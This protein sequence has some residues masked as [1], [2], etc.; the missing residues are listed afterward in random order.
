M[1]DDIERRLHDAFDAQAR[2]SVGDHVAPP[3]PRFATDFGQGR[4]H[5]RVRIL[6][7]LAAAAA[8][9]VVG[10]S[11]LALQNSSDGKPGPVVGGH[12]TNPTRP[13]QAPGAPVHIRFLNTDGARYGVG[14]PV[15]A[16][17]SRQ[18]TSGKALQH[19]TTATVN[20]KPINGGWYFERS[21][22]A[23]GYPIEAHWRPQ[24]YWPAH[25]RVH[26]EIATRGL[27][28]GNGLAF[29]DGGSV[30]FTTGA[31][32]VAIV[33]DAKHRMV[34]T[35]DGQ[36]LGS[37]PVSLGTHNTPTAQGIK[38]IMEKGRSIC[39]S[40]P[41]YHECGIKYTQRLTYSG[42][43]IVAA[44][45]N[46]LNINR[47]IDTSNGSTNLLPADAQY[48]YRTLEVGDVVEYPNADGPAM[49]MGSGYGDW[50]VPWRV[51]VRG[52]LIPT[53]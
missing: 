4:R 47:G 50:N 29:D 23:K 5:R 48:L 39:V 12:T 20:G 13:T 3:S 30:D 19:A 46:T 18:I 49:Q 51:W 44:P 28:A 24:D 38:V 25:A 10:A 37:Y 33:D 2:A 9:I 35:S 31:K 34:V 53:S 11:V 1:N 36:F 16:F 14:M 40:G 41:G 27:P 42:E 21:S 32:T 7:P 22:Y 52:G 43:Y 26:V 45:W 17:L 15:I 6:A 8:V